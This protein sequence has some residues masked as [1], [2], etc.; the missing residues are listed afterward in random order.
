MPP[1]QKY[2]DILNAHPFLLQFI[3]MCG[4][5]TASILMLTDLRTLTIAEEGL[6]SFLSSVAEHVSRET[7]SFRR[8]SFD[9]LIG[10]ATDIV[11]FSIACGVLLL[12]KKERWI[13]LFFIFYC[14]LWVL[15]L[16][17]NTAMM[18]V[19]LWS[20]SGKAAWYLLDAAMVWTFNILLFGVLFWLL[21]REHQVV[22]QQNAM[23]R[24]HLIFPES[25]LASPAWKGWLPGIPDYLY[26]AF[27]IATTLDSSDTL[28]VS[29]WSK[30]FLVIES[31]ISLV[32][33]VTIAARAI[34]I[35]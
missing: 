19:S 11:Y 31:M 12:F 3:V 14:A 28:I 7:I 8:M 15:L 22:V 20:P 6:F 18:V 30:C 34:N 17:M 10:F 16:V 2:K 13:R 24:T 21:D 33:L 35:I 29:R 25:V 27:T 4:L 5:S 23:H 26:V 9:P 1:F 32:L